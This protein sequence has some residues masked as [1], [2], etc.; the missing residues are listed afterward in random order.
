MHAPDVECI[1]VAKFVF[2]GEHEEAANDA[3]ECTH[4][5]GA[6]RRHEA[7]SRRDADEPGDD[8]TAEPERGG[9]ASVD[10][11]GDHPDGA[12]CGGCNLC[13]DHRKRGLAIGGDGRSG[14]EAEPSDPQE[15]GANEAHGQVVRWLLA[16]FSLPNHDAR[17]E[18][19]GAGSQVHDNS[20]GKVEQ[21]KR[22][23]VSATPDH[24]REGNIHEQ[25]ED[26]AEDRH[27]GELH[28]FRERSNHEP[29][30]DDCKCALEERE[31]RLWD[32]FDGESADA[33]HECFREVSDEG[34][35][36]VREDERVPK[37]KPRETHEA[38]ERH[39]RGEDTQH[40]LASNETTIEE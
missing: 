1:V 38:C 31:E 19:G 35:R 2:H 16:C 7:C 22:V 32:G 5:S 14:V 28:S 12:G 40:I 37:G 39:A 24:V 25:M 21:S 34:C 18:C 3:G 4:N 33:C 9:L 8:A 15:A 29:W 30:C 6:E 20:A 36:S 13:G 26:D 27:G 23:E 11:V 10:P 17:E